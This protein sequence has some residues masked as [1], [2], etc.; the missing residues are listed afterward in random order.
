MS[1]RAPDFSVDAD[2]RA[3]STTVLQVGMSIVTAAPW[4]PGSE[5]LATWFR[6]TGNLA[7]NLKAPRPEHWQHRTESDGPW[8]R[9]PRAAG[10]ARVLPGSKAKFPGPAPKFRAEPT[11][12]VAAMPWSR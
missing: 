2:G 11:R 9:R 5:G 8:P 4:A 6:G 7:A 3:E 1:E 12:T 10:P